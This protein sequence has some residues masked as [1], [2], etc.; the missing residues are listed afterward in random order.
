V[1]CTKIGIASFR[2][3]GAFHWDCTVAIGKSIAAEIKPKFPRVGGYCYPRGG[4]RIDVFWQ[5][6]SLPKNVWIPDQGVAPYRGGV[7]R[8]PGRV[9][10]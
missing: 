8:P 1:H 2:D 4:I 9:P 10:I 7:D 5:T 6:G 3:H